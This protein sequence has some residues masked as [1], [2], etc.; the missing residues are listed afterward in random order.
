MNN[1][2][3]RF[4]WDVNGIYGLIILAAGFICTLAML[5]SRTQF[6]ASRIRFAVWLLLLLLFGIGFML[7]GG[8]LFGRTVLRNLRHKKLKENGTVI[9]ADIIDFGR[10]ASV[11]VLGKNPF[12]AML[13]YLDEFGEEHEFVSGVLYRDR[14]AELTG[15]QIP[16]YIMPEDFSHYY[17][18]LNSVLI[19][20]D[21]NTSG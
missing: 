21:R 10:D 15:K 13:H 17:V 6:S 14:S 20:S 1:K 18:D 16:V 19:E 12:V 9:M 7:L 2:N 4:N 8:F 11:S 5:I 3:F